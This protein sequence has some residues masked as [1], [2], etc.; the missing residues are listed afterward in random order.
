MIP[1][2]IHKSWHPIIGK[3]FLDDRWKKIATYFKKEVQSGTVI[4]PNLPDVFRTFSFNAS[5]VKVIIVGLS[6]YQK[7]EDSKRIATGLAFGTPGKEYDTESLKIIREALYHQYC[8]VAVEFFFD[9]TLEYWLNQ[10][11]LLLN[12]ILTVTANTT[13]SK[14]HLHIWKEFI[15]DISYTISLYNPTIIWAFLGSEAK[16][17]VEDVDSHNIVCATHPVYTYYQ[18]RKNGYDESKVDHFK[19]E[20]FFLE[21]DKLTEK[22]YNNKIDWIGYDRPR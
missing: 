9:Y 5:D 12:R 13:N 21:I 7:I 10:G 20:S 4:C 14:E 18:L 17:L 19:H 2:I 1:P 11:V 8:E 22:I 6:P 15:R 3:Y 16:L